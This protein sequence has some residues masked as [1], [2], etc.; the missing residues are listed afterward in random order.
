MHSEDPTES[1]E[2]PNKMQ[3]K[4]NKQQKK[5]TTSL[6]LWHREICRCSSCKDLENQSFLVWLQVCAGVRKN[7]EE[8][9]LQT[10]PVWE[11]VLQFDLPPSMTGALLYPQPSCV[12]PSIGRHLASPL[13]IQVWCN[14]LESPIEGTASS[15]AR[16]LHSSWW[17]GVF[18]S[19][20]PARCSSALVESRGVVPL[21]A[22]PGV[23]VVL[24]LVPEAHRGTGSLGDKPLLTEVSL[25]GVLV[26]E[27]APLVVLEA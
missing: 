5:I 26:L 16:H 21:P 2:K 1:L 23:P 18:S 25:G 15:V 11:P 9:W 17:V 27:D 6:L 12:F 4:Q 7:S 24:L 14:K 3:R 19:W 20:T 22:T 13:G 8:V 10:R